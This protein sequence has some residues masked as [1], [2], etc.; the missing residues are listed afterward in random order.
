MRHWSVAEW[1]M[2]ITLA[3]LIV[4]IVGFVFWDLIRNGW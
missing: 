2:L 1:G 3:V 4:W